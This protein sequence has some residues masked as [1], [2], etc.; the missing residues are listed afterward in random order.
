[1]GAPAGGADLRQL[2]CP[3]ME[4]LSAA[5]RADVRLGVLTDSTVAYIQKVAGG[6]PVPPFSASS[7]LPGHATAMGK[8]ILAFSAPPTVDRVIE[9]GLLAYTP[10][11]LTNPKQLQRALVRI[12]GGGVAVSRW[13]LKVGLSSVAVP[14]F[15]RGGHVAAAL[16]MDTRDLSGD[17]PACRRR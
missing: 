17:L 8:A 9:C 10:Y 13:E 7:R 3:V 15:G 11:T 4:D 14:I 12:R 16:E 1:M 6:Q 5:T 2:A